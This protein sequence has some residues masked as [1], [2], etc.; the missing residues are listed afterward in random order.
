MKEEEPIQ[1]IKKQKIID[2]QSVLAEFADEDWE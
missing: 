2:F 1:E